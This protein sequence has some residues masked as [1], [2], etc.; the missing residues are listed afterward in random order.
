VIFAA[1]IP[2]VASQQVFILLSSHSGNFWIH[3]RMVL[4]ILIL[5]LLERTGKTENTLN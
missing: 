1:I 5:K 4:Y 3:P 2:C